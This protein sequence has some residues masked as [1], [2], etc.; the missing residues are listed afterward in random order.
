MGCRPHEKS[1]RMIERRGF[2]YRIEL[3]AL[4]NMGATPRQIEAFIDTDPLSIY[5][6]EETGEYIILGTW[7]YRAETAQDLLE[8]LDVMHN[9]WDEE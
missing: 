2:V 1:L 9:S 3:K 8:F 6:N 5:L 7:E 4:E